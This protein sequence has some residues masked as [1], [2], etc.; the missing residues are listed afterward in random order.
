MTRAVIGAGCTLASLS[1]VSIEAAAESS[2][3]IAESLV[4]AFS[5]LVSDS[6]SSRS[7]NPGETIGTHTFTAV[8]TLPVG[9]ACASVRGSTVSVTIAKVRAGS[10]NSGDSSNK[11]S[12]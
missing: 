1:T 7:I 8:S 6:T 3:T 12:D 9:E 2:C 10:T 11:G 5:I 4:G